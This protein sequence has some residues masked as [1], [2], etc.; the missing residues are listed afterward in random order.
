[1]KTLVELYLKILYNSPE[2]SP[3]DRAITTKDENHRAPFPCEGEGNKTDDTGRHR[4][5]GI[6]LRYAQVLTSD[7]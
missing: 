5:W 1:M 2:R 3:K 6:A 4:A 7:D